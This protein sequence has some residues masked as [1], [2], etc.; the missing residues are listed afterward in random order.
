[1]MQLQRYASLG[2]EDVEGEHKMPLFV[3]KSNCWGAGG[4]QESEGVA[5]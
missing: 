4:G 3:A 2:F 5:L 1:M